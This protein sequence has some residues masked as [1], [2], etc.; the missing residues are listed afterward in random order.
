MSCKS[1]TQYFYDPELFEWTKTVRAHYDQIR[2]EW[3]N[4]PVHLRKPRRSLQKGPILEEKNSRWDL[5]TLM[6]RDKPQ[7]ELQSF[8]P[9]TMSLI[10]TVNIYENLSFSI[11][12]PG[13]ETKPHRGWSKDIHRV[14]LAIDTT[15][16]AALVCGGQTKI[17]KNG[18]MLIF[19]DGEEHFAY[20]RSNHIR[21]ILIFDVLK[22]SVLDS[23]TS[24]E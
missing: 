19:D 11:F 23:L 12:Y 13:T 10:D 7:W 18:E 16:H 22:T 9:I 2:H 24:K 8:F 6:H 5:V 17:L 1:P 20:N 3:E 21:T 14:H 4:C 15:D